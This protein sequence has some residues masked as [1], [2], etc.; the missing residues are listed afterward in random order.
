MDI[1]IERAKEP[2][3]IKSDIE[4]VERKGLGHP[5]T[6]CDHVAEEL[7]IAL[8]RYY[9]KKFGRIL[10]HNIDKCLLVGGHSDVSFGGGKVITP[11]QMIVVGRA[12]EYVGNERIPLEEITRNTIYRF[13]NERLRFLEPEKNM[14]VETKIRTGSVD[15]RATFESKVPLANDT[16]I[17]VG[18]SPL[19]ETESLV[20]QI[21]QYLNSKEIKESYPMIGEDIKIMGIRIHD[22]IN[23]TIAVAM[24]S[25]FVSSIDEYF[26]IKSKILEHIRFFIK[27]LTSLKV[28]TT[29]NAAD[30]YENKIAYLTVT[31][32]SAECGDDGQ[33]G[34]GNRANG[35]ITPYR[36]M[37]LEA[38]AGKNP[39]THT[40]KLYNLV[41]NEISAE[42]AR[43]SRIFQGE[44]YMVSQIGAPVTE[45]QIIHVKAHSDL[46]GEIIQEICMGII[47][48]HLDQIPVLWTGILEKRYSLF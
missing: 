44:C 30:N 29:L 33:V 11:L 25:R 27:R 36:P 37:T 34:R 10:H 28:T 32:T 48:K 15:L 43:D 23:L 26:T 41:A 7:T 38:T 9:L 8:S 31:G 20:Y 22:H 4:I 39:V 19:T 24:V 1:I 35:L 12:V 18:F 13:F 6:L 5:D 46:S 14:L 40:G 2:L 45:P 21:E 42:I 47:K 3:F 17:G 16:S